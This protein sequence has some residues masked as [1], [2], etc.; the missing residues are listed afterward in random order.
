MS[1]ADAAK[2]Y[3]LHY[4]NPMRYDDLPAGVDYGV[5]DAAIQAGAQIQ[6]AAIQDN[7][8]AR[9]MEAITKDKTPDILA[10]FITIGFFGILA[11]MLKYDVPANN[12]TEL[13]MILGSLGTAW[14]A[15]VTFY[16][17]SSAGSRAKDITIGN[18]SK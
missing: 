17:G 6:V 10:F 9:D 3:R 14:I 8:S 16:Y 1:K 13:D 11:Y 4:A 2:I 5:L 18:L 15:V 7:K 12:K